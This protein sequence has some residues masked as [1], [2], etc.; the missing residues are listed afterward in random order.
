MNIS[1]VSAGDV[2]EVEI[3]GWTF[4]ARVIQVLPKSDDFDLKIHPEKKNVTHY[5]CNASEVTAHFKRMGR[6]RTAAPA[7]PKEA[8]PEPAKKASPPKKTTAAKKPAPVKKVNPFVAKVKA[9]A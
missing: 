2:V 8:K 9:K 1:N 5:H 4:L 6:T 3:R 7:A